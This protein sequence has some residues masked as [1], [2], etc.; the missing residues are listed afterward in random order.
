MRRT[1]RHR[2]QEFE[3][4]KAHR[5][6]ID[7]QLTAQHAPARDIVAAFGIQSARSRGYEADD[8]IGTL[9]TQG[10]AKGYHVIIL[11]GDSDQLQLVNDGVHVQ[12]TQRGVSE[13]KVYDAAAVRERYG[14][15]PG[16][17]ADFK[18]LVGDTS[19]NIPGVPGIGD[20]TASALLQKFGTL[21]TLLAAVEKQD[22]FVTPPKAKAALEANLEQ[23]RF[24]KQLATIVCDVPMRISPSSPTRQRRRTGS[25]CALCSTTWSS[26]SL[27]GPHS[28]HCADGERH[29]R[30]RRRGTRHAG[31]HV[32]RGRYCHPVAG[33]VGGRPGRVRKSGTAGIRTKRTARCPCAPD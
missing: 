23:A 4:Y 1:V 7:P 11:T 22:P 9:A 21:E 8:L 26:R 13:V 30:Q 31:S 24:S 29:G 6:P 12:I 33:R 5:P 18:A 25:A 14:I 20:K 19:D 15:G 32:Q 17:I 27:A 28:P 2:S 16:Q 10:K 3:A